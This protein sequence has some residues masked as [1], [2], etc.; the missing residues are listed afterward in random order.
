MGMLDSLTD[1]QIDGPLEFD[2]QEIVKFTCMQC[3]ENTKWDTLEILCT[4]E[5]GE[6]KGK[7]YKLVIR[8]KPAPVFRQFLLTFFSKEKLKQREARWSE[9][10]GKKFKAKCVESEYKDKKY[11]NWI[12]FEK[13]KAKLDDVDES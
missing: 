2:D 4:V 5:S 13:I 10:V 9:L 7:E 1:E 11:K 12:N 3:D 8:D 6:H